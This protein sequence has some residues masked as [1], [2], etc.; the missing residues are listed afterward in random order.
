MK[1]KEKYAEEIM[2][3]AISGDIVAI[4]NEKPVKCRDT[5]CTECLRIGTS[6][7]EYGAMRG[8]AESE[9]V[10][11]PVDWSKVPVD[12]KILVSDDSEYWSKR[13]FAKF[14]NEKV[15]ACVNG[16]TSWSTQSKIAWKYAK[17][18]EE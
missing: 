11:P 15:Y 4:V 8:W 17:L 9:Y 7:C 14:E 3:I 18:A 2:E 6:G 10:E 5:T 1:N 13:Y 12:T 16:A